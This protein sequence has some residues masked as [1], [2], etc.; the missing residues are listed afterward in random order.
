MPFLNLL[1]LTLYTWRQQSFLVEDIG[2]R[3]QG[4][5]NMRKW[6]L[7]WNMRHIEKNQEN[8]DGTITQAIWA[9]VGGV[10]A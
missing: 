7:K 3:G 8:G 4:F 5:F 6:P 2:S 9:G 10:D 1:I